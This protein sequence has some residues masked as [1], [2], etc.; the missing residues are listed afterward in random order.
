MNKNSVSIAAVANVI[1]C[2]IQCP[3]ILKNTE[4]RSKYNLFGLI[5]FIRVYKHQLV[6]QSVIF[7][8]EMLGY[9]RDNKRKYKGIK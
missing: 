3:S 4:R 8:S 2:F 7:I 6:K 5:L 9:G 1:L